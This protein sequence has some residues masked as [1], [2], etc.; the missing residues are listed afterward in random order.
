LNHLQGLLIN[1]RFFKFIVSVRDGHCNYLPQAPKKLASQLIP[2]HHDRI[3]Q[4]SELV[5]DVII[6]HKYR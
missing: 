6:Q 2:Q 4:T 5:K 3:Y 1:N